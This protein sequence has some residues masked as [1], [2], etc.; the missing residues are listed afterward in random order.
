MGSMT[1]EDM[2]RWADNNTPLVMGVLG[3]ISMIILW[4][5]SALR[6][7]GLDSGG[8]D[9]KPIPTIMWLFAGVATFLALGIGGQLS[10]ELMEHPVE[11]GPKERAIQ[12]IFAGGFGALFGAG[13]VWF[14]NRQAKESGTKPDWVDIPLGLGLFVVVYPLVALAGILA[15]AV[16]RGLDAVPQDRLAHNTLQL[17]AQNRDNEWNWALIAA[18]IV[19]FPIA[20]ELIYRVFFQSM[21]L[22]IV[23]SR[24]AAVLITSVVFTIAHWSVLPAGGKHALASLFVLS[25][26]LEASYERTGR[27]GVPIVMHAAF[28]ALN[29]VLAFVVDPIAE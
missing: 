26:A 11:P 15:Q 7:G 29:I 23:R 9:V 22:K 28:N 20:E 6:V 5:I 8:R 24:W 13:M 12:A 21:F 19:L 25:V 3:L 1:L 27:L 17:I 16:A 10:L 14:V 4:R 2:V 18:I